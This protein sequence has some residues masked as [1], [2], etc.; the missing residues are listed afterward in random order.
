V[1]AN[2]LLDDCQWRQRLGFLMPN[3]RDEW[4]SIE[5]ATSIESLGKRICESL[6]NLAIPEIDRYIQD[7]ALRDLWLS[8]HSPGLTNFQRLMNLSVLMKALGPQTKAELIVRELLDAAKGK[9]T[10][11]IAHAHIRRLEQESV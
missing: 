10:A 9:P 2:L 11:S 7:Q 4:W 8:G 6:E 3:H 1:Q 5:A